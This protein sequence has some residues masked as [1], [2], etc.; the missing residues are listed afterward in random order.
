M[1]RIDDYRGKLH[2]LD[3]WEPLLLAE[4]GLPGPRANLELVQAV[5]EEGDEA[6]FWRY[7]AIGPDEAPQNTPR[8]FLT[9]CGA[10]GLGR[11]LADGRTDTLDAL[12]SLASD[13]R[14]RTRE[15]VAMALQRLGKKDMEALLGYMDEWS[16]EGPLVQRAA[17][18]ALCEPALLKKEDI[19]GRVLTV[20]DVVTASL[21]AATERRS[22]DFKVLRQ[23]LGYCWSVAVAAS[24]TRGTAMM[25]RW[26][27]SVDKDVQWVMRENLKKNRLI[28]MDSG[29][30]SRWS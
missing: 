18:A 19:V 7:A 28:R 12:R 30:V 26:L 10:V 17:V 15:G 4:S 29:W 16:R 11:L 14:W 20:L 21:A 9:L 1:T 24:P 27:R 6:L 3:D 23:A 2:S 13:P 25:E 22:D 5:A 8:E